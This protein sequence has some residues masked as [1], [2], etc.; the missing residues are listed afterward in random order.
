MKVFPLMLATVAVALTPAL[1]QEAADPYLKNPVYVRT[2]QDL[3]SDYAKQQYPSVKLTFPKLTEPI[4]TFKATKNTSLFRSLQYLKT[5]KSRLDKVSL[6][7]VLDAITDDLTI[8]DEEAQVI[9]ALKNQTPFT[10]VL[11]LDLFKNI[12]VDLPLLGVSITS[13]RD[14]AILEELKALQEKGIELQT[15]EVMSRKLLGNNKFRDWVDLFEKGGFDAQL[16]L[17]IVRRRFIVATGN[18]NLGN[19]DAPARKVV[20]E[21]DA[22]LGGSVAHKAARQAIYDDLT[23]TNTALGEDKVDIPFDVLKP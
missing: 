23:A 20:T 4:T 19:N 18:S 22:W 2:M 11:S 15:H 9:E 14:E 3:N 12:V 10:V 17:S 21:I 7:V 13:Q 6:P 1:A 16:A 5:S 8:S